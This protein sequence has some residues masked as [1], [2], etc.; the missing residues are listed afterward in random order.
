MPLL[1]AEGLT[2]RFVAR[3]GTFGNLTHRAQPIA[4]LQSS[5]S[6]GYD[7]DLKPLPFDPAAAKAALDAAG[8]AGGLDGRFV[9]RG[10]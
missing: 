1:Q 5:L 6:F 3:R 8:V 9:F 7:P 4:S 2:V 10:R